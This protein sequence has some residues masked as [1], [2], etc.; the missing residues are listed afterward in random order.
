[1][2]KSK[3]HF[4]KKK[5]TKKVKISDKAMSFMFCEVVNALLDKYEQSEQKETMSFQEFCIQ[6]RDLSIEK[7][8]KGA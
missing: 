8:K 6:L 3:K 5:Q 4:E 1:M 7:V 2:A